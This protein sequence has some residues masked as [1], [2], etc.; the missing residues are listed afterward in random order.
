LSSDVNFNDSFKTTNSIWENDY[1]DD[2]NPCD[3]GRSSQKIDRGG[4]DN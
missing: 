2:E 1:L 3:K 4:Q